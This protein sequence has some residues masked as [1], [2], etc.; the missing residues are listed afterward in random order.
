MRSDPINSSISLPRGGGI[1]VLVLLGIRL[2]LVGGLAWHGDRLTHGQVSMFHSSKA[3][4]TSRFQEKWKQSLELGAEI[5]PGARRV[6]PLVLALMSVST[7][8]TVTSRGYVSAIIAFLLQ[9]TVVRATGPTRKI[10]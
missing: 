5:V 3:S 4:K 9:L 1:P 6:V 7:A 10:F 8:Q 2:G